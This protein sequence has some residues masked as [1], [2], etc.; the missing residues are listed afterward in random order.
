MKETENCLLQ[1]PE[2]QLW[3]DLNCGAWTQNGYERNW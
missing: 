2:S 1:N 3:V